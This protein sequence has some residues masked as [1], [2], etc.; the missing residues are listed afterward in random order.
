MEPFGPETSARPRAL[1]SGVTLLIAL[2]LSVRVLDAAYAVPAFRPMVAQAAVRLLASAGE[3]ESHKPAESA[4][5]AHFR[6]V[7]VSLVLGG[8]GETASAGPIAPLRC[9]LLNLPPPSSV[10][11]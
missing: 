9:E 1:L 8:P 4:R 2:T 10:H 7:A 3:L 6:P 11:A 5:P